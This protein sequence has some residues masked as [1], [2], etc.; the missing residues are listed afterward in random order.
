MGVKTFTIKISSLDKH[1]E[2][3]TTGTLAGLNAVKYAMGM[4]LLTLPRS[5]ATGDLIAFANEMSKTSE[6]RKMRYT[7]AGSVFFNRMKAEGLYLENPYDIKVKVKKLG[8]DDIFNL[9]IV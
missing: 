6:G 5:L 2:A 3:M 1:A 4:K 7:F 9:R 8:L